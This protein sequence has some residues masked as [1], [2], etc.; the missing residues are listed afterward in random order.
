MRPPSAFLFVILLTA[1]ALR[2][3]DRPAPATVG[4]KTVEFELKKVP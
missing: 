1:C 2:G 3:S 4:E